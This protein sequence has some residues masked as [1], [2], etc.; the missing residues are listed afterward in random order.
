MRITVFPFGNIDGRVLKLLVDRVSQTFDAE[1]A[2]VNGIDEPGDAYDPGRKQWSAAAFL[3]DAK[4]FPGDKVL[5]VTEVDL[6]GGGL[7]FV[8]GQAEV[9]GRAAV[10]SLARLGAADYDT[11]YARIVKE[12][13]HELGHTFGL[14]HCPDRACV[15]TFSNS[16]ADTDAKAA[17]LCAACSEAWARRDG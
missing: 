16:I 13:V 5:G 9:G 17:A 2:V 12:G 3:R 11:Y 6:F 1:A 15:M 14:E 10:I 8:F 4:A 7:N